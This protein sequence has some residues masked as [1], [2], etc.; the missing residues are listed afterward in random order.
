MLKETWL[1]SCVR[2]RFGKPLGQIIVLDAAAGYRWAEWQLLNALDSMFV[3][4]PPYLRVS[5]RASF[6]TYVVFNLL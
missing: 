2:N 6:S 1:G 4:Y 5:S 3:N